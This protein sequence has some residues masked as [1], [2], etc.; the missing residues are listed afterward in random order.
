MRKAVAQFVR[1]ALGGAILVATAGTL[2][3]QTW[4]TRFY[5]HE[6]N[7]SPGGG[8]RPGSPFSPMRSSRSRSWGGMLPART[9]RDWYLPKAVSECASGGYGYGRSRLISRPRDAGHRRVPAR[10]RLRRG[11]AHAAGNG[12]VAAGARDRQPQREL[13]LQARGP[14]DAGG[15]GDSLEL[16][17]RQWRRFVLGRDRASRL[18]KP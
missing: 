7:I 1:L 4:Q 18:L 16:L 9:G 3:A 6:Y 10:V 14:G 5:R 13:A 12:L 15:A 8:V 11:P 2:P 17:D